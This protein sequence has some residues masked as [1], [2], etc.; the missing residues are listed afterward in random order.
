MGGWA[1]RNTVVHKPEE[2]PPLESVVSTGKQVRKDGSENLEGNVGAV[3]V[4][5]QVT[6]FRETY[7]TVT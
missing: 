5:L 1:L 6:L 7:F 4:S 3:T 2:S